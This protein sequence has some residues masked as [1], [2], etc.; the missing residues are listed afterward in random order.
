MTPVRPTRTLPRNVVI[1]GLVSLLNDFASEMVV[2]LIP[3]LLATTLAAGPVA[4]G[5]IEG[6][7]DAVSNLLKLWAGRRSDRRGGHRKPYVVGGYLL[8]N[9]V[10]PLIGLSGHWSMV[11]G[12]RVTDRIGK[13]LRTAPRDALIADAVHDGNAGRA[14]GYTRALDHAG[15]VLGALTAAAVVYWG[16]DRLDIVIAWSALPGVLAVALI[17][18]GVAESRRAPPAALAPLRWSRLPP[19][20]RHYL[21]SVTLFVA[22]RIPETFLLLRGH[23]LG[24]GVVALLLLWAA[25]HVAKSLISEAGGRLADRHGRRPVILAGW[26]LY[27]LALLGLALSNDVAAFWALGFVLAGYY[28]LSEGAERALVRDLAD[29]DQRG[30]A[31]GWY[32]MLTG[33]AAVP[34]GVG[35]GVL[36]SL[37]GVAAAF[38]TSAFL[39]TLAGLMLWRL[40]LPFNPRAPDRAAP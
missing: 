3:L 22:G 7:A 35:L 31:F 33:L 34:A 13:G 39:A 24:L 11:L 37:Y 21:A 8:S 4:L 17:V 23:E 40:D 32:H 10:R 29:P 6:L 38:L 25:V 20:T 26:V 14:Y 28:G 12:I 1:I 15:A 36:W 9:L 5:L 30:T 16:T 18:F 27:A 2:P 19:V